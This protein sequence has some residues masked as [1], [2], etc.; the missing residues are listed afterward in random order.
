MMHLHTKIL[1]L[2]IMGVCL[3]TSTIQAQTPDLIGVGNI[4]SGD[5][6]CGVFEIDGVILDPEAVSKVAIKVGN[7]PWSNAEGIG[8]WKYMFDSRQI[9]TDSSYTYDSATGKLVEHY[10][11]GP[12]YGAL[13]I[14]VGAFDTN[15]N[16]V[17]TKTLN[18]NIIPEPPYSDILS[19]S[20]G[21][22]LNVILKAAPGLSI[23]YTLDGTDPKVNGSVYFS[24]IYVAQSTVINAVAK[25]NN[26]LY[27]D[28]YTLNLTVTGG[29]AQ[30]VFTIQYYYDEALT[31]PLPDSPYLKAGT[32]YLKIISNSKLAG[33]PQLS[34]QAPGTLNNVNQV[35]ALPLSDGVYY[36]PRVIT[37]DT[38]ATGDTQET[39]TFSGNDIYGNQVQ[40][41]APLNANIKAAFI[42]TQPPTSGSIG[43][44]GYVL[45]TS[46][47]MPYFLISS[48][49]ASQM[50]LA[51]NEADLSTAAWVDYAN[52]YGGFD[53]SNGG[54][55]P[56]TV[57]IEFRDRAGNIQPQHVYTTVNYDNSALGFDIGY[58][59]DSGLTH[60]MGLN[61]Y[62]STGTYYLKIIANQDLDSNTVLTV[63]IDAEGINNDVSNETATRIT[64]RIFYY[65]RT[66]INDPAAIGNTK[67]SIKI[68]G[69]TPLNTDTMAAF[70]CMS[71]LTPEKPVVNSGTANQ[72][73]VSWTAVT[74]A[75]AY[76]V[77]Y[78]TSNDSGSATKFGNDVTATSCTINGLMNGT[79]YFVWL[80]AKNSGGVS[81][82]SHSA[83]GT[84][85]PDIPTPMVTAGTNQ[86]TV[87]WSAITGASAYEV[88]INTVND[89]TS[90][91]KCGSD[92]M[93][94]TYT[95]TGLT[96]GAIYYI[97]LKSKNNGGTSDFS[98][99]A[100]ATIAPGQ[101]GK[102]SVIAGTN[103]LT[104]SWSAVTGASAYEVWINTVNDNTSA[105][106]FGSDVTATTCTINGLTNGT[107]YFVW[108]KAKNSAGTS[109]FSSSASGTVAP[110][111]PGMPVITSGAANQMTVSWTAVTGATAYEVWYNTVN[112]TSSA[113]K[114]GIDIIGTTCNISGLTSSTTYY[115][116]LKAKNAAGTS[117]FSPSGSQTVIPDI[118]VPFVTTG[119][120]QLTVTWTAVLGA[121]AYEVWYG[122]SG[123]SSSATKFGND[124]IG[125]TCM[126]TGLA[127]GT[128]YYVWVK[129]KN[130]GGTSNFSSP[131]NGVPLYP[132]YI[133]GLV[134]FGGSDSYTVILVEQQNV[135]NYNSSAYFTFSN[136]APG[137]YHV[138]LERSG[139]ASVIKEVTVSGA[140]VDTGTLTFDTLL[141]KGTNSYVTSVSRSSGGTTNYSL[142][143]P[144]TIVINYS[145]RSD[146]SPFDNATATVQVN[147]STIWS[148][149]NKNDST[150]SGTVSIFSNYYGNASIK[151][152]G[153]DYNY[154]NCS[155]TVQY[156][157]DN[158]APAIYLA[159]TWCYSS[160]AVQTSVNCTDAI[161]GISSTYYALTNSLSTPSNWIQIPAST[162]IQITDNGTWYL[163]VKATDVAGN[164][165]E[166]IEGPYIITN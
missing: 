122:T 115:V 35:S 129:A 55:G 20:Y 149:S 46:N 43:I 59:S 63:S 65:V 124:I 12:Y 9:V 45:S 138:K 135:T 151:L 158:E 125:T 40:N 85:I 29:T 44:E 37:A 2:L 23:Y 154:N 76:E 90:A 133:K 93:A 14:I 117:G 25:N 127:G 164:S 13:N 38:A 66:I 1:F 83:S 71:V 30:P 159:K 109:G 96:D 131:A 165:Y 24:S 134:N 19:G 140:G 145:L 99:S 78:G 6:K 5:M 47:P 107:T 70:T 16:Q 150:N 53:I 79:T 146:Y 147:G 88:W 36:Y 103:Q 18:V 41:A 39:I 153:N 77:W 102:P 7:G 68:M 61:P 130:S 73:T 82:F 128:N 106:K 80:K 72:L 50:R 118:P 161:S 87:S 108:L 84:V 104:V 139:Y 100:N 28:V 11:L 160:Q 4:A 95:I 113:T 114:L 69:T 58:Y 110:S 121:T 67:E 155:L 10:Q 21:S 111:A 64:N 156:G 60:S 148:K 92:V 48:N 81:N 152:S 31:K 163:H 62:L 26:N 132:G 42:D 52:R 119:T 49:R 112:D 86:L 51:L 143:Y 94:T 137:I 116:W 142:G 57:W 74:R 22:P 166:R 91:S 34:I 144:Q 54:N 75:T 56:K 8:T 33:N 32:Y 126:I 97:W 157:V 101:P 15:G 3:L 123:N 141:P 98:S 136:L 120:N 17:A 105:T 27:S 162:A 89:N